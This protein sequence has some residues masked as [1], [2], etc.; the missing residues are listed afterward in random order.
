[1]ARMTKKAREQLATH[2][3]VQSHERLVELVAELA[4][5]DAELRNRLLL[6]AASAGS[7]PVDGASYRRSF[8]DALR[9]GSAARRTGR[10][11]RGPGL[12][13]CTR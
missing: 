3:G 10:A 6:E 1:M 2:L 11:R 12:G 9:S 13:A 7:G 4:E 8:S 5:G